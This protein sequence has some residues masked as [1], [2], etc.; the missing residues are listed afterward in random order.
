M[1]FTA[2]A[3]I[4]PK[5]NGP[6]ICIGDPI[7]RVGLRAGKP[8]PDANGGSLCRAMFLLQVRRLVVLVR[9]YH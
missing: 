3:L 4:C 9:R 6:P 2:R 7:A 5:R 1:L 8:P